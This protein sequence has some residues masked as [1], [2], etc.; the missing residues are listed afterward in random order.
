M[1][2]ESRH[3]PSLTRVREDVVTDNLIGLDVVVVSECGSGKSLCFQAAGRCR[4]GVCILVE[5][6][7][8][9]IS[10]Q[11]KKLNVLSIYA[12]GLSCESAHDVVCGAGMPELCW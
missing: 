6:F 11:V 9:I 3:V 10:D 4:D 8:T 12:Y 7:V 2:A 1:C 5:P